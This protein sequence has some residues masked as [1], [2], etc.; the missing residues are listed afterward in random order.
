M[1]N[2]EFCNLT[3]EDEKYLLY[4]NDYWKVYLSD[5]QD[6]IG[7]CIIVSVVHYESL[8]DLQLSEWISLKEIIN[9]LETALKESLD[10]TMFNWSCLMN[11]SYKSANPA[12]HVHFHFRPRYKNP[13]KINGYEINDNEFARHY[14]RG[15]CVMI[16][17]ETQ[18]IICQMLKK[19]INS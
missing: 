15:N 3:A 8:S 14:S 13:I 18:N 4:L 9:L 6:Y 10:A 2:C 5:E 16:D 7:R 19:V 1:E 11:N 17:E 12:P